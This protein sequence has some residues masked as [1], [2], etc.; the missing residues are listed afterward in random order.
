M[1]ESGGIL[2][3]FI[4]SC[5]EGLIVRKGQST[6]RFM[7]RRQFCYLRICS[8]SISFLTLPPALLLTHTYHTT[9]R[10]S[11]NMSF[12]RCLCNDLLSLKIELQRT[13]STAQVFDD[14]QAALRKL[15]Q[16]LK[17]TWSSTFSG[18]Y[19]Q[20]DGRNEFLLLFGV[21]DHYIDQ[22]GDSKY[23]RLKAIRETERL[24]VY[25]ESFTP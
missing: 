7:E 23:L 5:T 3:K 1:T 9:S 13:S 14:D 8:F 25:Q 15:H 11:F 12:N 10:P 18:E 16:Q 19:D 21:V 4:E 17:D 6:I 24:I 2:T 22:P 20:D